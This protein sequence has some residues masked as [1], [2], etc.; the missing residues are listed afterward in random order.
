[1]Q[2]ALSIYIHIPFCVQKCAYCDFLSAP[3]TLEVQEQYLH[4]LI[5]EIQEKAAMYAEQYIIKTV[6]IGGGTPTVVP[7]DLLCRVL[8]VLR[9]QFFVLPDAEISMEC[10]PGTTDAAGLTQYRQAGINRL[11]I[12]L[13]STEDE[14]LRKLG[15]IHNYEQFL[16]TFQNARAAGFDNINID[17]MSG[18][19]GQSL[20]DYRQT[21][22]QVLA[23]NPEHISAYSLIVEEGTPFYEME[24]DLPDEDTERAMYEWTERMLLEKGYHRYEIS[25]YAKAGYESRHNCVYWERGE[26][27]GLG[28]GAS[29]LLRKISPDIKI[30]AG[31][32]EREKIPYMQEIRSKNISDLSRYL[33]GD[34]GTEEEIIL[35]K[36][37]AMEEFF[38]LGLRQMKGVSLIEFAEWFG[39]DTIDCF[40]DAMTQ[41]IRDGLLFE[42][43]ARLKLTPK[44]IDVSNLVFE[45]FLE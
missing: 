32:T 14:L 8:H 42:E 23:L 11:S 15:R 35:T 16:Q 22:K 18:L 39:E 20:N 10:N 29:S 38:F 19:P 40:T 41:S 17:L 34:F 9:E 26:Y 33:K 45:R 6:F 36:R 12:G 21:L 43:G 28:L 30:P 13:Q 4:R 7:V 2:R 44:G 5:Q 25:N 3:A 31:L 1:M 24:L 37:E 27:L